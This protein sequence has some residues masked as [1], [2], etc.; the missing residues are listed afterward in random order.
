MAQAGAICETPE[1]VCRRPLP[2]GTLD[3]NLNVVCGS[4]AL[5]IKKIKPAGSALMDFKDFAN[6][7]Q[8]MPGD[9]FIKLKTP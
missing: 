4:G 6:G 8:T 2:A 9:S 3:E 7:R 1:R 5:K